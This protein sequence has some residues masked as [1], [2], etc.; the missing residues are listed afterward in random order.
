[1]CPSWG[2][3]LI[4]VTRM[5]TVHICLLTASPCFALSDGYAFSQVE[6]AVI[7]QEELV[8]SYDTTKNKPQ[9]TFSS[10]TLE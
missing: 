1:M 4:S 5:F 8:R 3:V 6:R 2:G 10:A 9:K 7:S